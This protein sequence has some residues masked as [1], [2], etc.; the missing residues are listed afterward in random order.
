M[1]KPINDYNRY[2]QENNSDSIFNSNVKPSSLDDLNKTQAFGSSVDKDP[3]DVDFDVMCQSHS[4][5]NPMI[6]A[7]LVSCGVSVVTRC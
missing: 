6:E 5:E 1:N 4:P 7:T 3:F 2:F